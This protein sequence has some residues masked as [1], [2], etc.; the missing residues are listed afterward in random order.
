MIFS[1]LKKNPEYKDEFLKLV[2]SSFGYSKEFKF[3]EDF[4]PLVNYSNHNNCY[5]LMD[6]KKLIATCAYMYKEVCAENNH[7]VALMGAI[8]VDSQLRGKGMGTHVVQSTI[9]TLNPVAW[10][11]LWSEKEDFFSKFGFRR[12]GKLTY[13][14]RG[15]MYKNYSDCS[16][17]EFSI[18]KLL[19]EHFSLWKKYYDEL[20]NNF[21]IVKRDDESWEKLYEIKS[22]KFIILKNNNQIVGYAIANKGM[23]LT[24][25]VHEFYAPIDLELK[26]FQILNKK[27]SLWLPIFKYS[28]DANYVGHCLLLREGDKTLWAKWCHEYNEK[29]KFGKELFISGLDSI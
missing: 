12:Y 14:P 18:S 9:D 6:N 5:F 23:D 8:A 3:A 19:P 7:T 17:Q 26:F 1:N 24:N 13:L 20:R 4:Y 2:E 22:A 28:W 15:E 29:L 11:G 25:I 21:C 16:I 10:V 27:Y